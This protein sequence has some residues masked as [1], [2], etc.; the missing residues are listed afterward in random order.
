MP[1]QVDSM[2][3]TESR[4]TQ[5][6]ER[7][8]D[9][10]NST[11]RHYDRNDKLRSNRSDG[12]EPSRN[13]NNN[14]RIPRSRNASIERIGVLHRGRFIDMSQS[15]GNSNNASRSNSMASIDRNHSYDDMEN[16]GSR[17]RVNIRVRSCSPKTRAKFDPTAYVLQK[18]LKQEQI[19]QM[20]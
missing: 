13:I 16:S 19:N 5:E 17:T 20:R 14:N 6:L 4:L 12:R 10:L 11:R 3:R 18:K 2:K 7:L 8:E 9:T 1:L 15:R